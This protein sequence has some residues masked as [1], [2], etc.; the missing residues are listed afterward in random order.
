VS[1]SYPSSWTRVQLTATVN[2]IIPFPPQLDGIH[3]QQAN[4]RCRENVDPL[5]K[6]TH[7]PTLQGRI[8]DAASNIPS[9]SHPLHALMFAIYCIVVLSL[10]E[11]YCLVTFGSS[12]RDL[13]NTYQ[14]GCQQALLNCQFMRSSNRETLTAFFLF[15]VSYITDGRLAALTVTQL[16]TR[17][18]TDP[19]SLSSMSAVAIRIAQRIGIQNESTYTRYTAFEAEMCRRL[20]WALVLFD[21]RIAEMDKMRVSSLAPTWDCKPAT[22]INDLDLRPEMRELPTNP[23]NTSEAIFVVVRSMLG[24]FVRHSAFYLDFTVPALKAIA[25]TVQHP[26]AECGSL[27]TLENMMEDKYLKFCN[28]ENPLHFMAMW[29]TRAHIAKHRLLEYYA[30]YSGPSA[31]QTDAQRHT[32]ISHAL[33]MIECDTK[34]IMSPLTK[35]YTWFLNLYFPMPAYIHIVQDLRRRPLIPLAERCWEVMSE[36]YELR[37]AANVRPDHA[38]NDRPGNPFFRIFG[39]VILQGWK[40]REEAFRRLGRSVD[41][42]RLVT[43][44]KQRIGLMTPSTQS[45]DSEHADVAGMDMEDLSMPIPPTFGGLGMIYDVGGQVST[46]LENDLH[47]GSVSDQ[48]MSQFDWNGIDWGQ[49][50]NRSW[51]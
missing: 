23:G 14:F 43:S 40:A 51:S 29:I 18:Q 39:R 49:W 47:F 3:D 24:E 48:A 13:L 17:E 5:L 33:R 50:D 36:N 26:A 4:Y 12:K 15:L 31:Q 20:W 6:I 11:N 37:I 10:D 45:T 25:K 8:I 28:P 22:N 1:G 35:G 2:R 27:A 42:P 19:Q 9:I 41:E 21:A 16:S 7:T 32:A 38:I 46:G 44:I 30:E 34:L